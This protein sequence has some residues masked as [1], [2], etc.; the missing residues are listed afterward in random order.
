MDSDKQEMC[1]QA[2]KNSHYL[3]EALLTYYDVINLS[4]D[5]AEEVIN[6]CEQVISCMRKFFVE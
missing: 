6:R 1:E 2:S 3:E 4:A 5:E